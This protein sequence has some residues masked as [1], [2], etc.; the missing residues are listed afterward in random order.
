MDSS[1]VSSRAA[2]GAQM[3]GVG[4]MRYHRRLS[5][6]IRAVMSIRMPEAPEAARTP[7]DVATAAP[8]TASP[9]PTSRR[10]AASG[11]ARPRHIRAATHYLAMRRVVRWTIVAAI[12]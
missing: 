4:A 2:H 1:L 5:R 8:A 11:H 6:Y 3:S 12:G 9:A 10:A 7:A